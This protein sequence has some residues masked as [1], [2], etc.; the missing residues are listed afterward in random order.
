VRLVEAAE[1]ELNLQNQNYKYMLLQAERDNFRTVVE[2]G[3]ESDQAES[4]LRLVGA[5]L[6]FWFR[7]GSNCE[8]HDLALKA[9][10]SPSAIHYRKARARALNTAG[11]LQ[12]ILGE[13]TSA[14]KSLEEALSILRSSGD[15]VSL[16]WT[17]QFLGLVLA[18]DQEYDLADAAL[19]EGLTLTR[20]LM[21]GNSNSL[22][23]F[24][25][26]VDLLRGDKN[27]AKKTY[28]ESANILR[29]IGNKSFLAYPVRRLGYLALGQDDIPTAEK[30]FLE[31]LTLNHESGDLPGLT[32]SL[33]SLAVL[34]IRL[35]NPVAAARLY[36]VVEHR[37]ESLSV[38]FFPTDQAE[39]SSIHSLLHSYLDEAAFTAAFTEGWEMDEKQAL[40]LAEEIAETGK[41]IPGTSTS[42]YSG[43]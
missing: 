9:L 19:K 2:W 25:G 4:A 8:G 20:K 15:E 22:L 17:L 31:S 16:A 40:A 3:A 26:D 36:G 37:L 34:A 27:R 29:A 21:D 18:Y 28:E 41:P 13:T 38:N 1:P 32:A 24:L 35:D 43:L 14:R 42:Q 6:W 5:L 12:C 33:A 39:L 11:Y 7:S 23:F 30:L 10:A